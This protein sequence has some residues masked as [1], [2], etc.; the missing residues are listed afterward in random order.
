MRLTLYGSEDLLWSR[1]IHSSLT[2]PF[3]DATDTLV[4]L[5]FGQ[6][7]R[8]KAYEAAEPELSQ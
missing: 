7:E 5:M 8:E 1:F 2:V 6:G 3:G 4:H